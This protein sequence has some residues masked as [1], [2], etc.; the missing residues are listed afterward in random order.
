M[1]KNTR[2][3]WL[4]LGI[5]IFLCLLRLFQGWNW[6]APVYQME[7][8]VL[9]QSVKT[10]DGLSSFPLPWAL[11]PPL[12]AIFYYCWMYLGSSEVWLR[13]PVLISIIGFT[14]ALFFLLTLLSGPVSACIITFWM[15]HFPVVELA[16]SGVINYAFPLAMVSL[17]CM[18]TARAFLHPERPVR[19]FLFTALACLTFFCHYASIFTIFL[20]Y[21]IL[22]LTPECTCSTALRKNHSMTRTARLNMPW[23]GHFLFFMILASGFLSW[24]LSRITPGLAGYLDHELMGNAGEAWWNLLISGIPEVRFG[25]LY[26]GRATIPVLLTLLLAVPLLSRKQPFIRVAYLGSLPFIILL[27]WQ[28]LASQLNFYPISATR[29]QYFLIPALG[30]LMAASFRCFRILRRASPACSPQKKSILN[31]LIVLILVSSVLREKRPAVVAFAHEFSEFRDPA[32]VV[33]NLLKEYPHS[34]VLME[35]LQHI[36]YGWYGNPRPHGWGIL[37][38]RF[39]EGRVFSEHR[40]KSVTSLEDSCQTL[41]AFRQEMNDVALSNPD[42]VF[43]LVNRSTDK[44]PEVTT[45][46]FD[47]SDNRSWSLRA[48]RNFV[49]IRSY[50]KTSEN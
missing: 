50:R 9:E 14:A 28:A 32:L 25:S 43:L 11:H 15:L 38:S 29:H 2:T 45:C 26:R 12:Q 41:N 37:P 23:L 40:L 18:L 27:S 47:T 30:V 5:T 22:C 42:L 8:E 19:R 49:I 13:V 33:D 6:A 1:V 39:K 44:V 7:I 36:Y 35:Y 24:H 20:C 34:T 10:G 21:L 31:A 3:T 48:G 16:Y 46:Q 4:W 17:L